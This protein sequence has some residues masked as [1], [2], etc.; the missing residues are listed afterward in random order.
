MVWFVFRGGNVVVKNR[1]T[2][3]LRKMWSLAE[4]LS[5]QVQGDGG[6]LYDA[7]GKPI[8]GDR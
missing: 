1:D 4:A 7:S 6:Q 5:A 3:I 2:E 8:S